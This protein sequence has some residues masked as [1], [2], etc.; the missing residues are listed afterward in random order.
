MS[1]LFIPS[2]GSYGWSAIYEDY[3]ENLNQLLHMPCMDRMHQRELALPT[4]CIEDNAQNLAIW[5][6]HLATQRVGYAKKDTK[7]WEQ[8]LANQRPTYVVEDNAIHNGQLVDILAPHQR[9]HY[10]SCKMNLWHMRSSCGR[11]Y[12]YLWKT[13]YRPMYSSH[14][15]WA[16]LFIRGGLPTYMQFTP[17]KIMLFV[18]NGSSCSEGWINA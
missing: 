7:V 11:E 1:F 9:E 2:I 5:E 8:Q 3:L 12:C 18:R 14:S 4:S 6:Q 13:A 15:K 16:M 10:C 17:K